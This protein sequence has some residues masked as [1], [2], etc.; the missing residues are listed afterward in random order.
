MIGRLAGLQ[1][2]AADETG[3]TG[4]AAVLEPGRLHTTGSESEAEGETE[5]ETN[6]EQRARSSA[7]SAA[8]VRSV[9]HRPRL[10][11]TAAIR[12]PA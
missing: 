5:T 3:G 8:P 11:E 6:H 7:V 12:F 2:I 10:P 4:T 1:A 9:F